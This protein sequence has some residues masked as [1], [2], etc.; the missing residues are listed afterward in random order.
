M[1]KE[2]DSRGVIKGTS[3]FRGPSYHHA[4]T[5][6]LIKELSKVRREVF[7]EYQR[8]LIDTQQ[9]RYTR[10]RQKLI[11]LFVKD[12]ARDLNELVLYNKCHRDT[13]FLVQSKLDRVSWQVK[14]LGWILVVFINGGMLFYVYLFA[15]NQPRTHQEA[16]LISFVIWLLFE[17]F[18]SSTALVLAF[19]ILI[20]LYVLT[21]MAKLKERALRDLVNL[22]AKYLN[23]KVTDAVEE[24]RGFNAAKYL[25]PSWRFASLFPELSESKFILQFSTPWPKK[26]F[27]KEDANISKEYEDDA[28]LTASSQILLYFLTSLLHYHPLFQD[29]IIQLLSNLGLGAMLLIFIR[30]VA[31]SPWILAGIIIIVILTIGILIVTQKRLNLNASISPD[32]SPVISIG[33]F[34]SPSAGGEPIG[35]Q[36]HEPRSDLVMIQPDEDSDLPHPFAWEDDNSEEFSFNCFNDERYFDFSIASSFVEDADQVSCDENKSISSENSSCQDYYLEDS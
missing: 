26:R 23:E 11:Y 28:I 20:P 36:I 25:Y 3:L 14:W 5:E 16:W 17:I 22:R 27:G 24:N 10:V 7:V 12:L 19:H 30:L 1:S 18:I 15:Q 21:D 4:V 6:D 9:D 8:L 29:I 13:E 34:D 32:L 31:L 33:E 2:E 35:F